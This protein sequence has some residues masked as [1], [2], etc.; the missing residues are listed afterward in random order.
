MTAPLDALILAGGASSRMGQDKALLRW[1]GRAATL[2]LRELLGGFV[3]RVRLSRAE[4][5]ELPEG[6]SEEDVV[7]DRPIASG[8]LRGIL[9]ALSAHPGRAFLVVAVDQPLLDASLMGSLVAARDPS[10]GATCFL[11]S[12]GSLPDPMCAIYEPSFSVAASPWLSH[13]KGC[14]RKVLLNSPVKTL[15]SPGIR[16]KDADSPQEHA[17]LSGWLEGREIT[18]E[19]F[20]ILCDLAGEPTEK[21]HTRAMDLLGLWRETSERLSI[22]YPVGSFRPVRNDAFAE[23]SDPF[24]AGDRISFLPPVSGG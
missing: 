13:G 12:D 6:W 16:L 10:L 1:E 8:P 22:P 3:E 7:R 15:A 14:P 20:A 9:S 4:G 21:V 24:A 23:W 2:R 18:L 19:H 11:D 17:A 5:Q